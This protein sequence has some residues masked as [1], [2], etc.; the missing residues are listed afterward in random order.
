MAGCIYLILAVMIGWKI[1][2]SI[3]S[4]QKMK[5]KGITALWVR[6]PAA[7]G[8]GI[9][10]QS[11]AVYIAAWVLSVYKGTKTPLF[12]ANLLVMGIIFV[13]SIPKDAF[14]IRYWRAKRKRKR[15]KNHG[16]M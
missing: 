8:C 9:L 2:G 15:L 16:N 14:Q 3:L 6:F 7:F 5:E 11:W 13:V 10:L 4:E 1:T 12:G